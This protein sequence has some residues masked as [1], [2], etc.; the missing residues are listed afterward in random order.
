MRINSK[1]L[2][3]ISP[4]NYIDK[5]MLVSLPGYTI[6]PSLP[7]TNL[8]TGTRRAARAQYDYTSFT[9]VFDTPK[10][11]EVL[12]VSGHNLPS[13]G[14]WSAVLF[15]SLGNVV[16]DTGPRYINA[17]GFEMDLWSLPTS[18]IWLTT[19]ALNVKSIR[20]VFNAAHPLPGTGD[21]TKYIDIVRLW[22]G[23]VLQAEFNPNYGAALTLDDPS[24]VSRSRGGDL[25]TNAQVQ[26]RKLTFDMVVRQTVDA[27]GEFKIAGRDDWT[28]LAWK[29]GKR[30]EVL[31]S[32]YPRFTPFWTSSP[33]PANAT[34]G[35]R[36]EQDYMMI[37]RFEDKPMPTIQGYEF[38]EA[39]ISLLEI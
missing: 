12:C 26:T 31:I 3:C 33:L 10:K 25:Y 15:D 13:T 30:E 14:A 22:A 20:Y 17:P 19:A 23:E 5:A 16:Y 11:I 38:Y 34:E 37:G 8:Q 35:A 21:N 36:L 28:R 9:A 7:L 18:T 39:R 1:G 32:F 27:F 2:M 4:E 6:Y 29:A 24:E